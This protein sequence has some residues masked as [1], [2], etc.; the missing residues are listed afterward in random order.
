LPARYLYTSQVRL[1]GGLKVYRLFL[2]DKQYSDAEL[3]AFLR[4]I[5]PRGITF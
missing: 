5:S 2:Q 4:V 1:Q 3:P